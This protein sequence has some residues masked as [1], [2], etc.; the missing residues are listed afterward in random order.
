MKVYATGTFRKDR[1]EN[2]PF[3][4]DKDLKKNVRGSFNFKCKNKK[5]I[6]VKLMDSKPIHIVNT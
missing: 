6:L 4:S 3:L 2:C 1:L 5:L